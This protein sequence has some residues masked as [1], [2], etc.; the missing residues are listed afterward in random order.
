[1]KLCIKKISREENRW[2][3]RDFKFKNLTLWQQNSLGEIGCLGNP[4]FYLLVA[5]AS[6][7]LI[8]LTQSVRLAMVTYPSLCSTCVTYGTPCHAIRHQV[9]FT[10]P[11]TREAEDFPRGDRYF[12]HVPL[13]K[14]LIYLSPKEIY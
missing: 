3:I 14:Y 2:I 11:L 4:Y 13:L 12:K 10:Q 6:S 1:M 8:P 9:L 5:Y 7:F